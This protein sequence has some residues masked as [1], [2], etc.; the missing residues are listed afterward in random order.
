MTPNRKRRPRGG[1]NVRPFRKLRRF[2]RDW[3]G[4]G[5]GAFGMDLGPRVELQILLDAASEP[6]DNGIA[7]CRRWANPAESRFLIQRRRE[8]IRHL[9]TNPLPVRE[10]R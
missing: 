2:I 6:K 9:K 5:L 10:K 8:A 7:P 4:C 3:E 1:P